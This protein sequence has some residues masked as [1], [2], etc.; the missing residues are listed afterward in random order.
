MG[1]SDGGRQRIPLACALQGSDEP[2]DFAHRW[3]DTRWT[4]TKAGV[5]A[6][7]NRTPE[8]IAKANSVY[9]HPSFRASWLEKFGDCRIRLGFSFNPAGTDD[10]ENVTVSGT[11][12]DE[13]YDKAILA[14]VTARVKGAR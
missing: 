13:A 10:D 9:D 12:W 8:E 2:R 5:I 4:N 14:I 3:P 1:D 7:D 11:T 6:S